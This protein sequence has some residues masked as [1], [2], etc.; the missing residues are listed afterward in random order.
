MSFSIKRSR[1]ESLKTKY[2]SAASW[3]EHGGPSDRRSGAE[4]GGLRAETAR[5]QRVLPNSAVTLKYS[6]SLQWLF[7]VKGKRV[8]C[9]GMKT[10]S[11]QWF[12]AFLTKIQSAT[13]INDS[14]RAETS[15]SSLDHLNN[16]ISGFVIGACTVAFRCGIFQSFRDI[17]DLIEEM[18]ETKGR[19]ASV[20]A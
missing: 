10:S 5:D 8:M 4:P 20:E 12:E 11:D 13:W 7:A 17:S 14:C 2:S 9:K 15:R 3:P 16:E 19:Y 6:G 1:Q 18:L